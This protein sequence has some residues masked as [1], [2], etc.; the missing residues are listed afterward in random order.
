MWPEYVSDLTKDK[1]KQKRNSF[2]IQYYQIENQLHLPIK[3]DDFKV[4]T[5]LFPC[6][7]F[8]ETLYTQ[9]AAEEE[10]TVLKLFNLARQQSRYFFS[11]IPMF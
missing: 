1:K 10:K 6:G 2:T 5:L 3:I 11:K 7:L 8:C 9:W 4:Q